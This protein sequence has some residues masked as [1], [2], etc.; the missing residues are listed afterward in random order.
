MTKCIKK[1]AAAAGF[2]GVTLFTAA[3]ERNAQKQQAK[4]AEATRAEVTLAE[5]TADPSAPE[6]AGG[7][8]NQLSPAGGP[9]S[10]SSTEGIKADGADA[11]TAGTAD[12]RSPSRKPALQLTTLNPEQIRQIQTALNSQ[13]A[14]LEVNGVAGPETDRKSVV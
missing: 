4:D 8:S 12:A 1:V 11:T 14:K 10:V 3:C 9:E 2:L 13:G 6:S 5:R 7:F